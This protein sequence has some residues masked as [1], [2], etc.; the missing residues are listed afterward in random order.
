MRHIHNRF[1]HGAPLAGTFTVGD[2]GT[3]PIDQ[4]QEGQYFWIEGSVFNDGLH[5]YPSTDLVPETFTGRVRPCAIPDAFLQLV[6]EIDG[7]VER[8]G[9][10]VEGPYQSESFGGYSYTR[11]TTASSEVGGPSGWRYAFADRLNTWRKMA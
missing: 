8:Y 6:D 10:S 3:L 5:Q 4:L 11:G 1:D 9:G 2:D 7:W